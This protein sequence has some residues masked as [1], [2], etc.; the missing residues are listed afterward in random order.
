VSKRSPGRSEVQSLDHSSA[1]SIRRSSLSDS[2]DN[3]NRQTDRRTESYATNIIR[4]TGP[5]PWN[6]L[7]AD[8]GAIDIISSLLSVVFV[9]ARRKRFKIPI[10][11]VVRTCTCSSLRVGCDCR[12]IRAYIRKRKISRDNIRDQVFVHL[13]A[14]H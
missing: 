6:S 7:S 12:N 2:T 8:A 1:C 4:P 3:D 13:K 11:I 5:S 10:S 9:V 14:R